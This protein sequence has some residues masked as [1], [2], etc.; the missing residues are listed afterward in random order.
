MPVPIYGRERDQIPS[1]RRKE[2]RR[3]KAS[4]TR[5]SADS[6]PW[7]SQESSTLDI[8]PFVVLHNEVLEFQHFIRPL[9]DEH[10]ARRMVI[11]E[12]SL[13][14]HSLWECATVH[15]MGSG[16]TGIITPYR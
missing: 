7:R 16:L 11:D 3:G 4:S 5:M 9:N 15:V 14:I 1:E 10:K 6:P 13:I 12:L 2:K 8:H